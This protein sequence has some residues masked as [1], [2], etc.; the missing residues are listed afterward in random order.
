MAENR[1]PNPLPFTDDPSLESMLEQGFTLHQ[2]GQ[3]DQAE[4]YYQRVLVA[5]PGN[6]DAL[7]LTGGVHMMRKSYFEAVA[8]L[9]RVLQT[10]TNF[11]PAYALLAEAQK[12]LGDWRNAAVNYRLAL[13]YEPENP[14]LWNQ[15]GNV[16]R[17]KG[18]TAGTQKAFFASAKLK[19]QPGE[20]TPS[21]AID[22][23]YTSK[24]KLLHD[25]EQLRY[26]LDKKKI[27]SRHEKTIA[28][29]TELLE[30]FPVNPDDPHA[31]PIPDSV[32]ATF[33][34]TYN[35]HVYHR[36]TPA[37]DHSAINAALNKDAI[38]AD[39]AKN[40]P[41]ITFLDDFLTPEA[42]QAIRA[43]CL[44][45][46]VWHEFRYPNGYLGAFMPEG[47]FCPLLN[48]IV[49]E[50]PKSL[51]G[52][53]KDYK[54]INLWGYK[55]DSAITGIDMHADEAAINV[56]FWVTPDE[57][58]RNPETGG[59]VIWDKEAPLDWDFHKFN[60]DQDAM[61]TFL[62]QS[63]AQSV[64]VPHKQN[65]AVIFNSDL[66]HATDDIDFKDGYEN[67]RINVTLLYGRRH[68]E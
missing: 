23:T 68:Q 57:A 36:D 11:V 10:D 1:P 56:N 28:A 20:N 43:H 12:N 53:F 60:A 50:L 5:D 3:L 34:P 19:Y 59:L 47:F 26:L 62:A 67:R 39:Y 32:R 38:E 61:R 42:L 41:G 6:I 49:E 17:E 8:Y 21:D 58:N 22:F 48:Q 51:P 15:L 27:D 7:Y 46:M 2:N 14:K 54:L 24:T 55:Y 63:N 37:L 52:I 40:K 64:R 65:R 31:S 35:R 18:D 45:S 30:N 29:Y 44:E 4:T 16:L 9:T 13:D 25:I 33:A 66:F